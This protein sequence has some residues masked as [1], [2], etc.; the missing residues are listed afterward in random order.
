MYYN[1]ILVGDAQT[2]PTIKAHPNFVGIALLDTDPYYPFAGDQNSWYANQNNFWRQVRNF[3]LDI[4][5]L[6]YSSTYACIHWQ[7][8]QAT[9]LQNIVMNMRIGGGT[10]NKQWGIFMENGSGGFMRDLIF[11]GGA[12]G[13]FLG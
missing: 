10:A 4:T 7:V 12:Y 9:S 8:A 2:L 1:S 6:P 11:N 3:V 13:F 5:P